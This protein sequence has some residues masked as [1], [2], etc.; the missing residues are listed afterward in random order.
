M[1]NPFHKETKWEKFKSNLPG[2]KKP[3]AELIIAKDN[4]IA[5]LAGA[6][7]AAL[8]SF[9]MAKVLPRENNA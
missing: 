1:F 8:G 4:L 9:L 5:G 2:G 3:N 6:V 7:G